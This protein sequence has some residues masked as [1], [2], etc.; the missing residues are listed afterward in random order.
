MS[1]L[2]CNDAFSI[3]VLSI[4]IRYS[5]FLKKIF[6]FWK[7]CFKI[8]V[9]KTFKISTDCDI[10]TCQS[11]KRM[12]ILKTPSTFFRRIYAL[13]VG[14]KVKP[15]RKAFSSV[16]TKTN[17]SFAVKPAEG[18]NHSFLLS[19]WWITFFKHLYSLTRDNRMYRT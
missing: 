14:F 18:S 11:L 8:K 12:A 1:V 16:K 6:V 10:K 5:S 9:L 17:P 13:S 19:V 2:H 7:I 3:L 15:L 4:K